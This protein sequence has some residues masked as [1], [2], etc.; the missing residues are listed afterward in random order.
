MHDKLATDGTNVVDQL[1]KLSLDSQT[2]TKFSQVVTGAVQFAAKSINNEN[3]PIIALAK[4]AFEFVTK[5]IETVVT[6]PT[7]QLLKTTSTYSEGADSS[8]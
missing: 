3:D 4:Y 5:V 7:Q 8:I 2:N 6:V 1:R